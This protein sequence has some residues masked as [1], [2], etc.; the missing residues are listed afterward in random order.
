MTRARGVRRM[1][2]LASIAL[3]GSVPVVLAVRAG[4]PLRALLA[5]GIASQALAALASAVEVFARA[6]RLKALAPTLAIALRWRTALLAQ[7]AADAAGALTPARSGSEPAKLLMLRRD[8]A[9][10]G[11][12]GALAAAEMIFEVTG[13]V[14]V[15][16]LV[17]VTFGD[18]AGP[19]VGALAYAAVVVLALAG[20]LAIAR[21]APADARPPRLWLRVGLGRRR[22][23]T[24]AANA[25]EFADQTRRLATLRP[26]AVAWALAAT[27]AHQVARAAVLPAL[28]LGTVPH[29]QS[30]GLPWTRLAV[31]PFTLLYLGALLPAP[32]GGGGVEIAFAALLSNSLAAER[33]PALMLWWR[34][35]THHATALIG[36][37]T[38]VRLGIRRMAS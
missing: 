22:W 32:G 18:E 30:A 35:W 7:L 6:A 37:V 26:G 12:V 3:A 4:V 17:R 23:T 15:A 34:V 9:S 16:S 8:G 27:L 28:V 10:L 21:F 38:L 25:R 2:A 11:Q 36:A 29:S 14:L 5:L 20:L 33:L 1:G 31:V 13:L 24:L 19:V